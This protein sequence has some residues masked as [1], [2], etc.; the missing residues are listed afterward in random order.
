VTATNFNAFVFV[1]ILVNTYTLAADDYPQTKEKTEVLFWFNQFFTWAFFLEMFMKF[2]GLG[3]KNYVKDSFNLFD[4]FVVAISIIDW[5]I[6]LLMNEEDIGDA[7]GALQALR[8][9][10]L[11]RVIKLARQWT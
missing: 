2:I 1:L 7:A 10:R 6:S 11:L 5:T 9:M 3:P 4:A 8:A